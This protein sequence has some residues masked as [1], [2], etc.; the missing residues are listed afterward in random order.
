MAEKERKKS[1][2]TVS[3]T[4]V[5]THFEVPISDMDDFENLDRILKVLKKRLQ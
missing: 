5:N 2:Y 3:I 4:G 1:V